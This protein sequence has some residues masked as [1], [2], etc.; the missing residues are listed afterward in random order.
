MVYVWD[1]NNKKR[2]CQVAGYPTSVSAL[3][4]SRDGRQ[5]AV[6]SSYTWES[7]DVDHPADELYIRP[8][9]E[10]EVRPKPR[11]Q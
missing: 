10:A 9:A 6:A 2:L 11:V 5:L 3:A 8:I 1:G 7:G 4:F